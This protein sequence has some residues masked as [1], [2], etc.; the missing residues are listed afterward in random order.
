MVELI[1]GFFTLIG[2]LL[3]ICGIALL[4]HAKKKIRESCTTF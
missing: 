3:V 1:I 2:V 4:L